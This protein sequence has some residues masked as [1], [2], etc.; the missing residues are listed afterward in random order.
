MI[1]AA[2]AILLV[3][4]GYAVFF[5]TS[6]YFVLSFMFMRWVALDWLIVRMTLIFALGI[7][8]FLTVA[9]IERNSVK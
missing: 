2:I 7:C 6:G 8:F 5:M 1:R 3:G 9:V 4:I